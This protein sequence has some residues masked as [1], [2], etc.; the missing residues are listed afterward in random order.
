M[1]YVC[2]KQWNFCLFGDLN[3]E[4]PRKRYFAGVKLVTYAMR[5]GMMR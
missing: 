4:N 3:K 5:N 1:F 2:L